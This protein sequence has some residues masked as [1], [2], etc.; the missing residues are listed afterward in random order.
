VPG[1]I[2]VAQTTQGSVE[3]I[4]LV[5]SDGFDSGLTQADIAYWAYTGTSVFEKTG[6]VTNI[7]AI[8]NLYQE[9][10]HIVVPAT[11]KIESVEDLRGKRVAVGEEASGTAATARLV[12]AAYGLSARRVRLENL[13][14]GP[15]SEK[16]KSGGIPVPALADLADHMAIRLLP[17]VGEKAEALRAKHPF[18]AVDL[19]P[20]GV[21]RGVANTVTVGIG[22]LWIVR[23]DLDTELAYAI[24]RAL[25]H[26]ANRKLLD[27]SPVGRSIQFETALS[28]IPIPL[29]PGAERYYEETQNVPRP[30]T[31]Q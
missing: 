10:L 24:T 4:E 14:V 3:N 8:A 30:M 20:A 6:P 25:W 11:S 1:L 19:I 17:L 26:P 23:S 21:Y 27:S 16:L 7:A 22:A 15:A 31:S 5:A 13:P 18:L 2:A 9:S 12:L 28:G 29:H